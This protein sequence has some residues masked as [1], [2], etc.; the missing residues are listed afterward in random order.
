MNRVLVVDDEGGMRAALE[1]RFLR[2][3]WQV[4]YRGQRRPRPWKDSAAAC[5]PL[6]RDRHP[7]V[8]AALPAKTGCL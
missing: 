8:L 7:H 4:E 1:A 5:I 6:S 3:G 2:R